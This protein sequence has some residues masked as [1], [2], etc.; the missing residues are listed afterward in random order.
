M[1]MNPVG[2]YKTEKNCSEIMTNV[3]HNQSKLHISEEYSS[4]NR[5]LFEGL[6]K[7]KPQLLNIVDKTVTVKQIYCLLTQ[8]G[9]LKEP[10]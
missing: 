1:A 10:S 5:T 9:L 3:S 6:C 7:N 8:C 2:N 4:I